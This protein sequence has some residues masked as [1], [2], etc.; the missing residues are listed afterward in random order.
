MQQETYAVGVDYGTLS[1][2][3]PI[4]RVSDGEEL[5]TAG[6]VYPHGVMDATFAAYPVLQEYSG[7]GANDVMKRLTAMRKEALA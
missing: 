1:G 4:V 2:R 5:S 6:Y 3:A 7:H